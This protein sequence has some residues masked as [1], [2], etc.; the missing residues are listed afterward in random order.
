MQSRSLA[1]LSRQGF[2]GCLNA[3]TSM[4]RLNVRATPSS[5]R[6]LPSKGVA[7]FFQCANETFGN[8]LPL[9]NSVTPKA[10]ELRSEISSGY[11]GT[12]KAG[13][14][15][16]DTRA[17]LAKAEKKRKN[18]PGSKSS[19]KSRLCLFSL[20]EL[21]SSP[22]QCQ[23]HLFLVHLLYPNSQNCCVAQRA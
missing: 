8:A 19:E 11:I 18:C 15:C 4:S 13:I 22:L 3:V 5:S 16:H 21:S 14:R 10:N 23:L 20:L 7:R 12:P 9:L 2:E 17:W 6:W 1:R